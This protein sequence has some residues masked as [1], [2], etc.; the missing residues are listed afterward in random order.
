MLGLAEQIHRHPIGRRA[1]IGNHQNLARPC[2]HINPHHAKHTAFGSG[3]KGI[4]WACDFVHLRHSLRAIRQR[5]NGLCPADG[6]HFGYACDIRRRQHNIVA[7]ALRR[8]HD[9][10]DF[11]HARHMRRHGIH[12]H[13]AGIRRLAAWHINPH[14]IQRR[15]LLPQQ[16]AIGIGVVP[17]FL[18][19]V[20]MITAHALGSRLQRG[21]HIFRQPEKRRFQIVL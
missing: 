20:L 3:N 15:D 16:R 6:E 19:L 5:G 9:H 1:A 2:H 10:N 4:A 18:F 13:A 8:G 7:L 14:A 12:N 11:G 21:L 17:R